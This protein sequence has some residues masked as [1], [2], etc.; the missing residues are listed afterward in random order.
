MR[1]LG[2][3]R[4]T[5]PR[6]SFTTGALTE[7][8]YVVRKEGFKAYHHHI[9]GAVIVEVNSDG[10]WWVRQINQSEKTKDIYDISRDGCIRVHG[11]SV[12]KGIAASGLSVGD[13][14]MDEADPLAFQCPIRQRRSGQVPETRGRVLSR[15][16]RV[17]PVAS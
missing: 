11:G 1:T 16:V 6:Y 5:E 9:I 2:R 8:K 17:P 12:E 10:D 13:L 3:H 15:C 14:H 4:N 7:P